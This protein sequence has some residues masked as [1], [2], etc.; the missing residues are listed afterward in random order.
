MAK[1]QRLTERGTDTTIYPITAAE[2]VRFTDG[3]TAEAKAAA[4]KAAIEEQGGVLDTSLAD[5]EVSAGAGSVDLRLTPNKGEAAGKAFPM[6]TAQQAGAVTAAQVKAWDAARDGA[7]IDLARSYGVDYNEATGLFSLNGLTDITMEQMRVIVAAGQ[8]DMSNN[9]TFY[10]TSKIRTHLPTHHPY[11]VAR[12]S[13]TFFGCV[14]LEAVNAPH[15]TPDGSCFNGCSKLRSVRVYSPNIANG[16]N[17]DAYKG[18][19]ALETLTVSQ[20]YARSFSLADSPLISLDSLKR[21]INKATTGAAAMTI[22]VHPD[23]YAK[24]TGD[25]EAEAGWTDLPGLA[26][27]KNITFTTTT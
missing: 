5:V 10:A 23:V 18:C 3:E 26:A 15:L 9:S 2:A 22:T 14:N 24:I 11:S 4:T 13:H 21:I 17:T 16:F 25:A 19:A 8:L 12:G 1:I 6:A 27:P 7:F 20:V